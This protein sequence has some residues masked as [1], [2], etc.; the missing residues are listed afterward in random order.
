M[1]NNMYQM[2]ASKEEMKWFFDH[3][4]FKPTLTEVYTMEFVCRHKKLTD[5][6][7]QTL[8]LTR[9]E[10]E[11]LATQTVRPAKFT[12]GD[13]IDNLPWSFDKW[14]RHVNRFNVCTDGFTTSTGER[15]PQKTLVVLCYVNPGDYKKVTETIIERLLKNQFG[16]L[17]AYQAGKP[18]ENIAP[19]FQNMSNLESNIKHL[20]ANCKG[21]VY[22]MDFDIDV[23]SWFKYDRVKEDAEFVE[24]AKANQGIGDFEAFKAA[25]PSV[26]GYYYYKMK[27]VFTE[28]FGKRNFVIVDTGGGY[29]VLV[30]T[31][32][33]SNASK[34]VKAKYGEFV[35]NI[36]NII[37]QEVTKI[38][39]EGVDAGYPAHVN[40]KGD[41]KYECVLNNSQI[42]GIPMPGTYQ[43]G[44]PVTVL[45][46][47]DFE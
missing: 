45:N 47:E 6:E 4:I 27:D 40:E 29:H 10:A 16:I 19:Q 18:F 5:E 3:C 35:T 9:K 33:M 23:P 38:Y 32:A 7:K 1:L 31:F 14:W 17:A 41:L 37:A 11:F 12:D 39:N 15:L 34:V 20:Q 2:I 25:N 46:K 30:R 43:Y 22:W 42:P 36:P 13:N 44:R 26:T 21:T 8:G 24:Y 28:Y